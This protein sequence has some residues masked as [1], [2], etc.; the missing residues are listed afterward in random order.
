MAFGAA[1]EQAAELADLVGLGLAAHLELLDHRLLLLLVA[2][3]TGSE[4]ELAELGGGHALGA[5]AQLDVDAAPGHVGR[6]RDGALAARLGDR[7]ALALGVLGLRVEDDV[8]HAAALEIGGDHLRDLDRDRPDEDRLPGLIARLDLIEDGVPLAVLGLVDLVVVVAP[9]HRYVGRDLDRRDL[10]DLHELLGLGQRRARHAGEL[11]VEAEV[12]LESDRG[13]GLVLLLDL[14]TLLRLNRLV[15]ALG[16]APALEDPAREL[17]DDHHLAF[18][19][20]VLDAALVERLGLEG[21]DQVVDEGSVLTEVEV[22]DPQELLRLRDPAL[23][24]RDGL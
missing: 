16:P 3:V 20:L 7:L 10:V 8:V 21:L 13:E 11:V 18:D 4:T 14:D 12:V 19:E 15:E 23:G 22:L 9:D 5:A 17:V 24:R 6:D 1:D 2:L